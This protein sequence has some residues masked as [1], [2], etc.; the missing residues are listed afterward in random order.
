MSDGEQY[1]TIMEYGGTEKNGNNNED[2]DNNDG[3][4]EGPNN[5]DVFTGGDTYYD[6]YDGEW[7]SMYSNGS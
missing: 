3:D 5:S 1:D 2:N 4:N 6:D 7:Y